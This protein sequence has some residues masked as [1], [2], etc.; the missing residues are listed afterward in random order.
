MVGVTILGVL[1]GRCFAP[2]AMQARLP[3]AMQARLPMLA[4]SPP[5][6][7]TWALTD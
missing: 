1:V 4:L 5:L 6:A 3:G 2:G 7:P